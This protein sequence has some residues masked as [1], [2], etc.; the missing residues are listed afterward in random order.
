MTW[1]SRWLTP[2]ASSRSS[3]GKVEPVVAASGGCITA[4]QPPTLA[5]ATPA[6]T[7]TVIPSPL[8]PL[9]LEV[10]ESDPA[11]TRSD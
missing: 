9:L 5:I 11:V 1:R 8:P 10:V 7:E 6:A 4:G 3:S 2:S